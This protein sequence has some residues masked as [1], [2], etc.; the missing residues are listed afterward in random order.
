MPRTPGRRQPPN[1]PPR[2]EIPPVVRG[3]ETLFVPDPTTVQCKIPGCGQLVPS[4]A[5]HL[6]AVHPMIAVTQYAEQ[7]PDAPLEGAA[8][9]PDFRLPNSSAS[10]HVSA[11]EA[12]EHPGGRHGAMIEKSLH[13]DE[14]RSYRED[15]I[16][17]RDEGFPPSYQTAAVAYLMA[18]ARRIRLHIEGVRASSGGDI[19]AGEGVDRLDKLEAKITATLKEMERTRASRLQEGETP[20]A[21]I[22]ETLAEAEAWIWAHQG[23]LI[24]SC[25]GCGLPLTPPALPHW[26]YAPV[27]TSTGPEY[28]VWSAELWRLVLAGTI[29]LW[30]MAYALRTSPEGLKMVARRR[31]ET[32]PDEIALEAEERALREVLNAQDRERPRPL[33]PIQEAPAALGRAGALPEAPAEAT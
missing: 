1:V 24:E 5:G 23:E 26:A 32:W 8:S 4:I 30:V 17:L 33:A 3:F 18:V 25:V 13:R 28:V 27:E 7:W 9:S 10:I 29:P 12:A 2:P 14:R 15:V 6:R 21:V 19:E 11:K 31:G 16:A 22:E 20:L